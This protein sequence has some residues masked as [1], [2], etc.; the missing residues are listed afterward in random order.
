ME[1]ELKKFNIHKAYTIARANS[2]GMNITFAKANY[3]FAGKLTNNTNISGD[4]ESMNVWY[5][6]LCS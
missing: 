2:Y 5:K 3:T 1:N 4:I 6:K